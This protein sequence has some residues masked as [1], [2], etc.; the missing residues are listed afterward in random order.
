M[1]EN[2]KRGPSDSSFILEAP[3]FQELLNQAEAEFGFDH[4]M[5]GLTIPYF[6]MICW[7]T[8]PCDSEHLDHSICRSLVSY[9][10]SS[11]YIYKCI[12]HTTAKAFS[13]SPL[14][15]NPSILVSSLLCYS[16][17]SKLLVEMAI[18]VPRIMH[19]KQILRQSKLFANQAASTSTDVPKG[20]FAVYVGESQMKRFVV[21]ISVLNQPSF[22]KLLSIAEEEFGFNH[23]MG[24]LTIPCREEVFIDLTSRLH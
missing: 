12:I 14:L 2:P 8:Q 20:Y 24:G 17:Y 4:P 19:A 1:L 11:I 18:R 5:G 9:L 7:K 10:H 3:S 21:P 13:H 22:Q 23:P 15:P 6:L 16:S